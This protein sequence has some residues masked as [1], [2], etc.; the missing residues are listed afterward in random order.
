[1]ARAKIDKE[2][3]LREQIE[4]EA[5]AHIAQIK[6]SGDRTIRRKNQKIKRL[7]LTII[8]LVFALLSAVA[9]SAFTY[10]EYRTVA[11]EN[12]RLSNPDESAKAETERIQRQVSQLIDVPKDETPIIATVTD[13]S[14]LAGQSFYSKAENGDKAL[15]Y[16]KAKRAVLYRPSSNKIIETAPLDINDSPAT[17]TETSPQGSAQPTTETTPST[18]P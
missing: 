13:K 11:K 16:Q 5:G 7:K 4:Q 2:K 9:A 10:K 17:G 15:F 3:Q 18:S 14:K 8:L 6:A 1:M 12:E